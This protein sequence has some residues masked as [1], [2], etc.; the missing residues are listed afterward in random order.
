[1]LG[2]LL[3]YVLAY[4]FLNSLATGEVYIAPVSR[5][6]DA[7]IGMLATNSTNQTLFKMKLHT[8][9]FLFQNLGFFKYL[10][11]GDRNSRHSSEDE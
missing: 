1:M 8:N 5:D 11:K 6:Y 2:Y 3:T 10:L 9:Y 4:F 7:N